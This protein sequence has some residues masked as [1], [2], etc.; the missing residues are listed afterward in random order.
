M[1]DT[2]NNKGSIFLI[3]IE[4]V[5]KYFNT[6]DEL[7]IYAQIYRQSLHNIWQHNAITRGKIASQLGLA[8][9]T[10]KVALKAMLL[11]GTLSRDKRGMYKLE[12]IT[13]QHD[14]K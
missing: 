7:L 1:G 8:E 9:I 13:Q 10:I 14:N 6:M 4:D 3:D 5:N 11:K 12:L 2:H